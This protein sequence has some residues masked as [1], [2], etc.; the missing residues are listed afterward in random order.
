M[1]RDAGAGQ[2]WKQGSNL[3]AAVHADEDGDKRLWPGRGVG[4][5]PLWVEGGEGRAQV[6][7]FSCLNTSNMSEFN[8]KRPNH[9]ARQ[10]VALE[11]VV[12]SVGV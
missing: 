2:R 8:S 1:A 5:G 6:T 9:C 3:A 11:T 10:E 4:R 7:L 12:C